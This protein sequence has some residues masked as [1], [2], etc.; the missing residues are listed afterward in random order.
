MAQGRRTPSMKA[1]I[2][3]MSRPADIAKEL[4]FGK[5]I[6]FNSSANCAPTAPVV[7]TAPISSGTTPR[8][9]RSKK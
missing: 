2:V 5:E 8:A 7:E 4:S 1:S 9:P 3:S 6:A